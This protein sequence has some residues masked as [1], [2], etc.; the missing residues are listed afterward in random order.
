MEKGERQQF[1]TQGLL[2]G[3]GK[4]FGTGLWGWGGLT[5][6]LCLSDGIP[7]RTEVSKRTRRQSILLVPSGRIK[8][9]DRNGQRSRSQSIK[10]NKS[11]IKRMC[12]L[13]LVVPA[14][15]PSTW[16]AEA[17]EWCA[18]G[19]PGLLGDSVSK[20]INNKQMPTIIILEIM[21]RMNS[22]PVRKGALRHWRYCSQRWIVVSR[23]CYKKVFG[24][25]PRLYCFPPTR[26]PDLSV[27]L[28]K[29][30]YVPSSLSFIHFH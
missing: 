6:W 9:G 22:H 8:K 29:S 11:L 19:Q 20:D 13:G 18:L 15:D 24:K 5:I 3:V 4:R 25:G 27:R 12:H 14:Y 10:R 21:M 16:E 17:G 26:L 30:E 7:M 23:K 2:R 1:Y 28:S